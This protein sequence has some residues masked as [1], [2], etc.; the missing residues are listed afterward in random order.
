MRTL[1]AVLLVSLA[2]CSVP[3]YSLRASSTTPLYA[4][5]DLAPSPGVVSLSPAD[6]AARPIVLVP[7][8]GRGHSAMWKTG[9]IITLTSI[10][11]SLV[12]AALTVEGMGNPFEY[13]SGGNGAMFVAGLVMSAIGDGGVFVAGPITWMAGMRR[14]P[15]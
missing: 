15:E 10:G 11:V 8:V 1:A 3:S 9:A 6:V 4:A 12:G 5:N 14:D 7:P 2:G 13:D